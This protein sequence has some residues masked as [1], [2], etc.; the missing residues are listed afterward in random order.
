MI[1]FNVQNWFKQA[2]MPKN[3]QHHEIKTLRRIFY[4]VCGNICGKGY[5][6]K[7]QHEILTCTIID[8]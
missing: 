2:I 4:R 5:Y 1:A 6:C 7:C 8:I 3:I